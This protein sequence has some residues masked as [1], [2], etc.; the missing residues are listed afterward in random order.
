MI[1]VDESFLPWSC[2]RYSLK[3]TGEVIE[4][5]QVIKPFIN[6]GILI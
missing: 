6:F 1:K 4:N 5:N 2:Y 3:D